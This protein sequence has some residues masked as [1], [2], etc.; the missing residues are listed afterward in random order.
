MS[1]RL[2]HSELLCTRLACQI[3]PPPHCLARESLF[4]F[5]GALSR[6]PENLL[7]GRMC[8]VIDMQSIWMYPVLHRSHVSRQPVTEDSSPVSI[9]QL[10]HQRSAAHCTKVTDRGGS[11]QVVPCSRHLQCPLRHAMRVVAVAY[12]RNFA[13][14]WEQEGSTLCCAS[15]IHGTSASCP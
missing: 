10:E 2:H 14:R 15:S 5:V 8:D 9:R 11:R 4:R 13:A 6:V 12:S 3:G 7:I 1:V